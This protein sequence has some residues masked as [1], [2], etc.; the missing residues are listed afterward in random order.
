MYLCMYIRN[1]PSH[2][3]K[4]GGLCMHAC[5]RKFTWYAYNA[6]MNAQICIHKL[7][8]SYE[9]FCPSCTY[10]W[11]LEKPTNLRMILKNSLV[12]REIKS[13]HVGWSMHTCNTRNLKGMGWRIKNRL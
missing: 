9:N 7:A 1:T 2:E 3:L 8:Y 4:S 13:M 12:R 10:L 11:F 5:M 6:C